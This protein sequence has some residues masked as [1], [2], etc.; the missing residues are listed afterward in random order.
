MNTF[1]D[2]EVL[3]ALKA[4]YVT[5]SQ[6]TGKPNFNKSMR[7]FR[8]FKAI[9]SEGFSVVKETTAPSTFYDNLSLLTKVVPKAQ[10]Q[11]FESEEQ[12]NVVPLVRMIN[13]DFAK[14]LPENWEEPTYV[15]NQLMSA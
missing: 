2:E 9:K 6:K 10:L 15:Y 11:N 1:N 14:Q 5:I 7:V 13:V 12:S 3:K 4:K 8:F